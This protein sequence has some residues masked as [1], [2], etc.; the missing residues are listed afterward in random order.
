MA[1]A[2]P[3]AKFITMNAVVTERYGRLLNTGL[4]FYQP[5]GKISVRLIQEA[6][7]IEFFKVKVVV[8]LNDYDAVVDYH[9]SETRVSDYFLR[10]FSGNYPIHYG[11]FPVECYRIDDK[12]QFHE[13]QD[14]AFVYT[15]GISMMGLIPTD[16]IF[17]NPQYQSDQGIYDSPI[18]F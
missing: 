2:V 6:M 15:L 3:I 12:L 13:L 1:T 9:P 10:T 11:V 7:G 14:L 5:D 18:D 4:Y 16:K 8:I 17:K